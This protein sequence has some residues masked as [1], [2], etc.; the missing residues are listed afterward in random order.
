MELS[1]E[2]TTE[3]IFKKDLVGK[4]KIAYL[5]NPETNDTNT[6]SSVKNRMRR[7]A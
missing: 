2:I 4:K 3:K 5:C 1:S 7:K 6:S